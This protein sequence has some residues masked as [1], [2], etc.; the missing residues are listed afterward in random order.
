V[1]GWTPASDFAGLVTSMVGH[2][3]RAL[4]EQSSTPA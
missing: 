1:L 4:A 3:V 2:D